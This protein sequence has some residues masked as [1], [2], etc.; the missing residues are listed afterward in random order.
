MIDKSKIDEDLKNLETAIHIY[1]ATWIDL[2][3]NKELRDQLYSGAT[4]IDEVRNKFTIS[5]R[6]GKMANI[7][8]LLSEY[9]IDDTEKLKGNNYDFVII[10]EYKNQ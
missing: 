2:L 6:H 4:T 3:N 8:G 5:L 9:R 10:D 1:G 7:L